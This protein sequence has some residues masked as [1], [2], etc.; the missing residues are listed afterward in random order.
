[1]DKV[2]TFCNSLYRKNINNLANSFAALNDNG[3]N[4]AVIEA[5]RC[6]LHPTN[7]TPLQRALAYS[8]FR[9]FFEGKS[10]DKVWKPIK[11]SQNK[12]K[13]LYNA[14]HDVYEQ[15]MNKKLI[16]SRKVS[17]APS[18]KVSKAPSKKVSKAPSRKAKKYDKDFQTKA[19]PDNHDPL[20]LYYT[21]LYDENPKSECSIEWLTKHGTF[22]GT[23]RHRLV[24]R[25]EKLKQKKKM[26]KKK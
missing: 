10:T 15:L 6:I 18:R 20:I 4:I 5:L 26:S 23:K 24:M 13:V 12:L 21:S 14:H 7:K 9:I 8:L 1:M 17:K 25:Y 22:D 16:P 2:H 3:K 11:R 19:T